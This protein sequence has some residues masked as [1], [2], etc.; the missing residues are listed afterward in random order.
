MSGEDS[1]FSLFFNLILVFRN[2]L[3]EGASI[4]PHFNIFR[5]PCVFADSDQ[6]ALQ[7]HGNIAR[8]LRA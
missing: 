8:H 3:C 4:H 6:V 2:K 7:A 5:H 1:I